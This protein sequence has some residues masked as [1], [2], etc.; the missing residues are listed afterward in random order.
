VGRLAPYEAVIAGNCSVTA[1]ELGTMLKFIE[2]K[3]REQ[4]H[5]QWGK[6]PPYPKLVLSASL[7]A[8]RALVHVGDTLFRRRQSL[9]AG[10][11]VNIIDALP[12]TQAKTGQCQKLKVHSNH[13]HG[14]MGT[15]NE[16]KPARQLW[17]DIHDEES[18]L[19]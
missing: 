17:A 1:N 14:T 6:R 18:D 16:R 8:G 2:E 11:S 4:R 10:P 12:D 3:Q 7:G 13:V 15:P 9:S 5:K 19:W